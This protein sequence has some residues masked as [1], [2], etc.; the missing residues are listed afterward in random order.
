[1][2]LDLSTM[3]PNISHTLDGTGFL[4]GSGTSAEAGYPMMPALTR[5]VVA[6]LKANERS[7]LDEVLSASN[8]SYDA[9]TGLPNIEQI[10]D[11]VIAHHTNSGDIRFGALEAR[12][13]VL[14][15]ERILAVTSPNIENHCRFLEALKSRSFGIPRSVWIF[16]T[17]Y[18]L[19][20]EA[21]ASR[22]GVAIENGFCGATERFFNP[23]VF[24]SSYG[25][26]IANRFSQS[27]NLTIRLVKLHGSI[28]WYEENSKF[29]ERYP[30]A[31][32]EETRRVII[33]PRRGKVMDT[34]VPPYDTLFTQ[35][36]RVMGKDCKYLVSCGF[37][38]SD[39]H[40]NQRLLLPVMQT[41]KCRLF[42]LTK[43]EPTGFAPFKQLPNFS[44]GVEVPSA[45]NGQF[46][47]IATNAWK[48]SEF[49]KLFS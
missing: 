23:I 4:F 38:F 5:E 26:V 6:A 48:F 2:T 34:L 9:Q 30:A 21:A 7:D 3:L 12:L 1:M 18:D 29:Y 31:S 20:F 22:V 43:E 47:A 32:S 39:E 15:L 16:T 14:I 19:L 8:L 11:C 42:A 49:V 27:H 37:S 41:G 35:A 33:F 25:E 36:S 13:R 24:K 46:Q 17:N 40:I 28:S 44:A 45:S 10:S